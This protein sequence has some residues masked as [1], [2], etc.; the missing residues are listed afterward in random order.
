MLARVYGNRSITHFRWK[1]TLLPLFWEAICQNI[2][3]T[4]YMS[5]TLTN[6]FHLDICQA[7]LHFYHWITRLFNI[8][9][10]IAYILSVGL[11][12]WERTS[13]GARLGC[14]N[15]NT[16]CVQDTTKKEKW[17]VF[18]YPTSNAM[19]KQY[20]F[21]TVQ[22]QNDPGL[23]L[24]DDWLTVAYNLVSRGHISWPS[25]QKEKL[26]CLSKNDVKI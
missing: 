15:C 13:N 12:T 2:W 4:K 16:S 11:K 23:L 18:H 25:Q 3:K 21:G 8:K 20:L 14:F 1:Y 9:L 22:Q 26:F 10:I 6:K 7:Y 24:S 17:K 19:S 5:M